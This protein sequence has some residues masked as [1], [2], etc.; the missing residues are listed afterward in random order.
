VPIVRVPI[1]GRDGQF[2]PR[3][4]CIAELERVL[5][6]LESEYRE[7][8]KNPDELPATVEHL[9]VQLAWIGLVRASMVVNDAALA[10]AAMLQI[11]LGNRDV[12][13]RP[14]Y[15]RGRNQIVSVKAAIEAK[16]IKAAARRD[17]RAGA[18]SSLERELG[19]KLTY[20]ETLGV[21]RHHEQS[22]EREIKEETLKT[23][24]KRWRQPKG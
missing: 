14:Y 8:L 21:F 9:K 23:R 4:R 16:K 10:A 7:G 15:E 18:V 17:K 2:G 3:A 5:D 13:I 12:T 6:Q 1:I 22:N 19:R 11:E 20:T 24:V